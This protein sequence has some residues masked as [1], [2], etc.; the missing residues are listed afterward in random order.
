MVRVAAAAR[1]ALKRSADFIARYGGEEFAL[2]LPNTDVDGALAVA[3]EVRQA[4]FDVQIPHLKSPLQ[5]K[6]VTIS[7][8]ASCTLP[9]PAAQST[10]LLRQAD[11]ALYQAKQSGR[12]RCCLFSPD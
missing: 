5:E 4:I 6:V 11:Q 2:L 1:D 7:L 9:N 10:Q 8:G 3:E 12:N